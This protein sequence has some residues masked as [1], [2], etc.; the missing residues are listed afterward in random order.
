[1]SLSYMSFGRDT[2]GVTQYVLES[3]Y[4]NRRARV[5]SLSRV[6]DMT[7]ARPVYEVKKSRMKKQV[8]T[9]KTL[10]NY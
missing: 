2:K 1:M 6:W 4:V 10:F 9:K 8:G 5:I 7:G 3:S